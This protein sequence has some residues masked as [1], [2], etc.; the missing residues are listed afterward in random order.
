MEA[1]TA[2]RFGG[3]E[4]LAPVTLPTPEPG[5][6]GCASGGGPPPLLGRTYP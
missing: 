6:G 4:V 3:P 1:T 2:T 5:E